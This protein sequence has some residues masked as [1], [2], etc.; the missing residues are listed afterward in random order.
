M[1]LFLLLPFV[2]SFLCGCES[3]QPGYVSRVK[4]KTIETELAKGGPKQTVHPQP[5]I[6][7]TTRFASACPYDGTITISLSTLPS[8]GYA[9]N[10]VVTNAVNEVTNILVNVQQ[11]SIMYKCP[12]CFMDFS[13]ARQQTLPNT[14]SIRLPIVGD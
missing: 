6:T 3:L 2:V 13:D 9:T 7:M 4:E 8:G 5:A 14:R 1:K 10:I 11:W 12:L